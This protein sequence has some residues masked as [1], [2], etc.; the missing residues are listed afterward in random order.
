MT[1]WLLSSPKLLAIAHGALQGCN[2]LVLNLV[3]FW[4]SQT[5]G[6]LNTS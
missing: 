3:N 4:L 2:M 1:K 6:P 5:Q